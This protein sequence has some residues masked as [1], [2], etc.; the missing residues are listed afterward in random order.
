MES[1]DEAD[2]EADEEVM[3]SEDNAEIVAAKGE[4]RA[5]VESASRQKSVLIFPCQVSIRSDR[6]PTVYTLREGDPWVGECSAEANCRVWKRGRQKNVLFPFLCLVVWFLFASFFLPP[7]HPG[8]LFCFVGRC[9]TF[10]PGSS[11]GI[12]SFAISK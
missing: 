6:G 3:G 1:G 4:L 5:V 10:N 2:N 8:R 9:R 12:I 11:N 7:L